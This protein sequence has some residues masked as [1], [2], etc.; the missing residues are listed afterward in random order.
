MQRLTTIE[1][2]LYFHLVMCGKIGR[3]AFVINYN[4]EEI[5]AANHL[6]ELGLIREEGHD[7]YALEWVI[8]SPSDIARSKCGNQH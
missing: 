7:L 2:G 6:I 8:C 3:P 4:K 5:A 1:K